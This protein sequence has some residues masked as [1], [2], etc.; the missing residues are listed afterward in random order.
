VVPVS[1]RRQTVEALRYT[2]G[3]ETEVQLQL[4]HA[5]HLANIGMLAAG[6]GHEINNPLT[7]LVTNLDIAIKELSD[8]VTQQAIS[9]HA[10]DCAARTLECLRDAGEAAECIRQIVGDLK[11]LS[12]SNERR[13]GATSLQRA[14]DSSLRMAASEIR[15]RARLVKDYG[16]LPNVEGSEVRLGQVFLN[17]LLNAAHAIP[18]GRTSEH[19]IR[20]SAR[21][22]GADW[23]VVEVKDTGSGIAPET[24]G[25]IFDPFFTT[26]VASEGTGLGLAICQKI[27]TDYRG[28]IDVESEAGKGSVFRV[29]LR[30]CQEKARGADGPQSAR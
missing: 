10:R 18:E 19:E 9:M 28:H 24:V 11:P 23:V 8:L 12:R 3:Q 27:V 17:L 16:E 22:E 5:N 20:V 15:A 26:K 6:I 30:T 4:V 2:Q 14:L 25:R 13:H 1:G 29:T 21:V 7:S